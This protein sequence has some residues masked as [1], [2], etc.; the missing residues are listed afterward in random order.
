M[1]KT[2]K[3]SKKMPMDSKARDCVANALAEL[4]SGDIRVAEMNEDSVVYAHDADPDDDSTP[5][6]FY[7]RGFTLSPDGAVTFEG[8]ARRVVPVSRFAMA[9]E[10]PAVD[11]EDDEDDDSSDMDEEE[12]QD[13]TKPVSGAAA[14]D[15]PV[16]GA[17]GKQPC[18]CQS[19]EKD[20]H[21]HAERI[22]ALVESPKVPF[23]AD[24]ATYLEGLSDERFAALEASMKALMEPTAPIS[25]ADVLKQFPTI[26]GIVAK[27]K[28][29]E[30]AKRAGLVSGLSAKQTSFGQAE[31]EAMPTEQLEKIAALVA[32]ETPAVDYT[33][34][35]LPRG[36]SAA[37]QPAVAPDPWADA[38]KARK[39][40]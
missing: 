35:G 34:L 29:E 16:H 20:M 31:L 8:A 33:G 36:A 17:S 9:E 22:R 38:L 26:A 40:N 25:E 32:V 13:D 19:K 6:V 3:K 30:A 5:V 1:A 21:R 24:D 12:S 37:V 23:T 39:G 7:H 11:E 14:Q 2:T 4:L 18:G 15:P 27:A 28:A 10:D